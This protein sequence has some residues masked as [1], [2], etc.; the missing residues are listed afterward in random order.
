M[1]WSD[2]HSCPG[3]NRK[4]LP[5]AALHS[6]RAA[7]ALLGRGKAESGPASLT[8]CEKASEYLQ[9]SLATTPVGSSID[10]VRGGGRSTGSQ[11]FHFPLPCRSPLAGPRGHSVSTPM[12]FSLGLQKTVGLA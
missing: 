2:H 1:A 11:H 7:R 5:R 8:V 4:P 3:P 12:S 6:F 10:K 9:D